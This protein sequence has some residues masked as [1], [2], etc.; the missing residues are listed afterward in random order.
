MD[1]DTGAAW[2]FQVIVTTLRSTWAYAFVFPSQAR[3]IE[4][5][6]AVSDVVR[7]GGDPRAKITVL[8][9]LSP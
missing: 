4:A 7:H 8:D 5:R 1:P 9:C 6:N 3:C 2:Q